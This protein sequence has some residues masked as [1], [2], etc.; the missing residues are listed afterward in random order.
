MTIT[1][2][3]DDDKQLTIHTVIG[4]ASFEEGM[5]TLRQFW[6]GRPTINVLWDFRKA[7]LARVTAEETEET[8]NYIK[9]HSAKRSGGKTALVVSGELEYGLS[10]MSQA[11]GEIKNLTLEIEVF[12][13]Y[14]DAIE[15]L[16]SDK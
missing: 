2:S 6:E 8:M 14:E 12:R 1:S 11:F 10:R 5:S 7:S 4:E 9:R 16:V 15:W 3:V 13:S